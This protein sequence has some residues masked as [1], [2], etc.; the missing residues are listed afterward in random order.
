MINLSLILFSFFSIIQGHVAFLMQAPGVGQSLE[1]IQPSQSDDENCATLETIIE[2]TEKEGP[3]SKLASLYKKLGDCYATKKETQKAIEAYRLALSYP[4]DSLK[5][6][7]R[8]DIA[9]FLQQNNQID[10][11]Q[12]TVN[13][14]LEFYPSSRRA[15]R[16]KTELEDRDSCS[17]IA[18][19]LQE[20][21]Q[22][23]NQGKLAYGY[24]NLGDCYAEKKRIQEAMASYQKA[25]AYP[26]EA[27]HIPGRVHAAQY[28]GY[29]GNFSEAIKELR[30]ILEHEANHT[31]ALILLAR[32]LNWDKQPLEG[33]KY[34]DAVLI[35]DP[36]NSQ[37]L[38]VKASILAKTDRS[39]HAISIYNTL[40]TFN[41]LDS[42]TLFEVHYGLA[43][44]L[45]N[46]KQY[47]AAQ[48]EL[49]RAEPIYPSHQQQKEELN[50][51]IQQSQQPE[52]EQ[53]QT[54]ALKEQ[55][56]DYIAQ[57]E[58]EKS[59]KK[60]KNLGVLYKNLG[61]CYK[62]HEEKPK[63]I[64]PYETALSYQL[65]LKD[66][67]EIAAFLG[68]NDRYDSAI[69]EL[70]KI[71]GHDPKNLKAKILIAR[72]LNWRSQE[73]DLSQAE[74]YVN[75][76]LSTK[77]DDKEALQIKGNLLNKTERAQEAIPIFKELE[78][79]QALLTPEELFEARFGL[80]ESYVEVGDFS[81]A[82]AQL[83][84]IKTEFV[85]Q[86]RKIANLKND[87]ILRAEKK[88]VEEQKKV[89]ETFMET[90]LGY[91][92]KLGSR[93]CFQAAYWELYGLLRCFPCDL[94]VHV[95]L[96]R[97]LG[98]EGRY[99]EAIEELN[100]VLC[101]DP[102]KLSALVL[103]AA[104]LTWKND[105][106]GAFYASYEAL[107]QKPCDF[108]VNMNLAYTELNVDN[109]GRAYQRIL[110]NCPNGSEQVKE[111]CKALSR[112]SAGPIL[113]FKYFVFKDSDDLKTHD[114]LASVT[115]YCCD[116]RWSVFYHHVHASQ[117][118]TRE[119]KVTLI[120]RADAS[121]FEAKR[122]INPW[123]DL[124]GGIG[125]AAT[126]EGDFVTGNAIAN[127]RTH[128]GNF[129]I[130]SV[131]DLYYLTAAA[132]F[133]EIRTWRSFVHYQYRFSRRWSMAAEYDYTK[134]SDANHSNK[135]YF[136]LKYL[137][138][139]KDC[140]DFFI[141]YEFTY[142]DFKSQ[143]L[144]PFLLPGVFGGHGYFDPN[145]FFGNLLGLSFF[146]DDRKLRLTLKGYASYA[147]YEQQ[148]RHNGVF[149]GGSAAVAVYLTPK[150]YAGVEFEGARYPLK[151]LNNYHY[152][153]I[154]AIF[155]WAF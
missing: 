111:R 24:K 123:L 137:L 93:Y 5:V 49:K 97:N 138:A 13:Q 91:A 42:E 18:F 6:A 106:P 114:Y 28:L 53:A 139:G 145:D 130:G 60:T 46:I 112:N 8:L 85:Y 148:G 140:W 43:S 104:V 69:A 66:R 76:V 96:A 40:L 14:V 141:N 100:Y 92:N 15:K 87:I 149:Y 77:P 101:Q 153:T 59:E 134:Y 62:N 55:C 48:Q 121:K 108:D 17:G 61:D 10:L 125:Y 155:R 132:L 115:N 47:S 94:N 20:M 83:T 63:A 105:F 4:F 79:R 39:Q 29:Q 98:L 74:Q 32:F 152:S 118:V 99:G 120:E 35:K 26:F 2:R 88:C 52:S 71:I 133:F 147:T 102:C 110:N 109:V 36:Q 58:Q 68:H 95:A 27:F 116:W 80:A 7:D 117:P 9:T 73:N 127:V 30:K 11:A 56:L 103:K 51:A 31:E 128:C 21:E 124:I 90:H 34:V 23:G 22:K 50:L 72:F 142:L 81:S 129:Q 82:N 67:L 146:Y 25:L 75:V 151:N 1:N 136:N 3:R 12:A 37:A 131:Y 44:A 86:E 126:T 38:L 144:S 143:I 65:D 150:S 154:S 135:A 89:L 54:T 19:N 107:R 33:E 64:E 122:F 45:A 57:I 119:P 41:N 16:I 78:S 70:Q 113:D 84:L